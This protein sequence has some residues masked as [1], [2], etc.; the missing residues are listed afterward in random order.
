MKFRKAMALLLT[1]AMVFTMA[2]CGSNG[3]SSEGGSSDKA[4]S[5]SGDVEL[6]VTSGIRCIRR[7][8]TGRILDAF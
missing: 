5:D 1:G 6:S 8:F 2:G 7:F 4:K 3:G